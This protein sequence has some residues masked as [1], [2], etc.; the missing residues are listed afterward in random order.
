RGASHA[1]GSLLFAHD[2][3]RLD[4]DE[5][6]GVDEAAHLDHRGRRTGLPQDL[7][8]RATDLLPVTRDVDDVHARADDVRHP[9]TGPGEGRIDV[10]ERLDGLGVGVAGTYDPALPVR[11]RGSRD[12]DDPP[13]PHGPRVADDRLPLRARGD[14]QPCHGERRD[15]GF[16]TAFWTTKT[17]GSSGLCCL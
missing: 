8:V 9:R 1:P 6:R 15:Q 2:G 17:F 3:F 7:A 16:A 4:L 11:G 14:L 13:R 12:V 10:L 5:H